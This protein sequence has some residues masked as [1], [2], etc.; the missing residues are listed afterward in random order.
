MIAGKPCRPR[1]FEII[2]RVPGPWES[3]EELVA[4]L[5]RGF[6]VHN[7]WLIPPEGP[8]L[9]FESSAAGKNFNQLFRGCSN[10]Q[11]LTT[12]EVAQLETHRRHGVLLF[13][14]GSRE[15]VKHIMLAS[16]GLIEAGGMGVFV[17]SGL[18]AHGA[19]EWRD[20]IASRTEVFAQ[21]YAFTDVF[22]QAGGMGTRGMHALGLRDAYISY[23][24][25]SCPALQIIKDLLYTACVDPRSL[26]PRE[27]FVDSAGRSFTLYA[28]QPAM[29]IATPQQNPYGF[30][31]LDW[32]QRTDPQGQP[33]TGKRPA[34][35]QRNRQ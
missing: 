19:S 2:L 8:V 20:L 32:R 24:D 25:E 4:R 27:P 28:L 33:A 21:L 22:T 31:F 16:S 34:T 6:R 11:E 7:Q 1:P 5:P 17:D 18:L 9:Y 26:F 10:Q 30:W 12:E 23:Q 35:T 13:P 15:A 3:H 14:G 29:S